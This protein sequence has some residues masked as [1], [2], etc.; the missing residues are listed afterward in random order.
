[1]VFASGGPAWEAVQM[2][3]AVPAHYLGLADRIGAI[4]VG[5]DANLT[6]MNNELQV[7]GTL[8]KGHWA[9]QG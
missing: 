6:I 2:A 7:Q 5:M 8:I 1:M 3:S 9:Y 4:A